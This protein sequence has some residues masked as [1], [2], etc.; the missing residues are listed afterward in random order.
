MSSGPTPQPAAPAAT[1]A[2]SSV[3]SP[4]T[5][6]WN[7]YADRK[8]N[9]NMITNGIGEHI[10][11]W[12]SIARKL[13][14]SNG[15]IDNLKHDHQLEGQAEQGMQMLLKWLKDKGKDATVKALI[16]GLEKANRMDV[17]ERLEEYIKEET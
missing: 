16:E 17:V 13:G 5:N 9:E 4:A 15:Q 11:V 3:V 8:V 7:K 10:G 14:F 6:P 2:A 12:M 1:S